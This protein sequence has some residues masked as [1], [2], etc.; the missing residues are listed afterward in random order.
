MAR[1][2]RAPRTPSCSCGSATEISAT[3]FRSPPG[4]Y[5]LRLLFAETF[6]GPHNRGKGGPGSRM[7]NVSAAARRC[8]ADSRS[9]RRPA[10]RRAV[11]KVF[12]GLVP[13]AQ[14]QIEVAFE[15]VVQYAVVNALELTAEK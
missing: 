12:H 2:W 3:A 5:T 6:F 15:P 13:N 14:G 7:F 10:K 8:S 1:W 9:S 11:E 4:R